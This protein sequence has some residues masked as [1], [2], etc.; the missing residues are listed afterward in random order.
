[1]GEHM[2]DY[3]AAFLNNAVPMCIIDDDGRL[4]SVNR[5]ATDYFRGAP[6]NPEEIFRLFSSGSGGE[7]ISG[8]SAIG[9]QPV[10][11]A[12]DAVPVSWHGGGAHLLTAVDVTGHAT[13]SARLRTAL[14]HIEMAEEGAGIGFWDVF[15]KEK[16]LS[17]DKGWAHLIGYEA[18]E[19][20]ASFEEVFMHRIHPDDRPVVAAYISRLDDGTTPVGRAEFRMRHRDGRWIWMRSVCRV[21]AYDADGAPERVAGMHMD[22]TQEHETVDALAEAKKKIILL[23]SVTRHDILNQVSVILMCD[24][25]VRGNT[26]RAPMNPEKADHYWDMANTAAHSIERLISFTRDYDALGME[27]PRWQSLAT[28]VRN[29]EILLHGTGVPVTLTC[30]EVE[31]FADPLFEKVLYNLLENVRRHGEGASRVKIAFAEDEGRGVLTVSD[32]GCGVPQDKKERIFERGY[33]T[34]TGLG[35]YLSREM[36]GITGITITECGTFG[37]GAVFRLDIPRNHIRRNRNPA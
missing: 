29:A 31:V 4:C 33:G 36:L 16:A 14:E 5:A 13:E 18:E 37:T 3:R 17:V 8:G 7:T 35:L 1:M 27:P 10:L 12:A 24:E 6:P 30:G 15:V 26:G 34:N 11:I 22:I 20:G 32:D 19:L 2:P 9:G 28:V 21:V 25:L 23:S